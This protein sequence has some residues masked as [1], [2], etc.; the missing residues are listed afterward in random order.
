MT[1]RP[2]SL[3]PVRALGGIA[4]FAGLA[5]VLGHWLG[6]GAALG[7]LDAALLV[8]TLG[9]AALV[10]TALPR[11]WQVQSIGTALLA[12]AAPTVFLWC[13][14]AVLQGASLAQVIALP[15][16]AALAF[17][18][19]AIVGLM[20]LV[21]RYFAGRSRLLWGS[22]LAALAFLW[23]FAAHISLGAA[24]QLATPPQAGRTVLITSLPLVQWPGDGA[25]TAG[26]SEAIALVALRQQLGRKVVPVGAL[27]E[28]ELLNDDRL[29]LAHPAALDPASL[30]EIDRFVRSGGR[31]VILA[32]GLSSWPR[33]FPFGDPRNPVVT[34]MLTPLLD[35]WGLTLDAPT[36]GSAAGGAVAVRDGA[37]KLTLHSPGHFAEVPSTCRPAGGTRDGRVTIV[38]CRIGQGTAVI[39]ADA[40]MLFGPLWLSDPVWAAHLR[41]SDNIKWVADQLNYPQKGSRWGLGPT[42]H[43]QGVDMGQKR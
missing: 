4:L 22:V 20:L 37:Y 2:Q 25:L 10:Y 1:T 43:D 29:L 11:A 15:Q 38:A 23:W 40:D 16:L 26:P 24:Y 41:P 14:F 31:A 21:T 7:R 13:L 17:G 12:V 39:L 28:G 42:W 9:F 30:V 8:P 19:M 33:P 35:H 18:T 32:D 5:L 27:G 34:S 36:P 6:G 3:P